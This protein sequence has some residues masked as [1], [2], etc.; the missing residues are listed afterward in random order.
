VTAFE[1]ISASAHVLVGA[2]LLGTCAAVGLW[3]A[4]LLQVQQGTGQPVS[5]AALEGGL[6]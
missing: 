2:L 5:G 6:A 1:A 3:S 4:R